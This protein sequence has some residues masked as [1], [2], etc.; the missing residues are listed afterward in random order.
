MIMKPGRRSVD[1]DAWLVLVDVMQRLGEKNT[2]GWIVVAAR[3]DYMNRLV[4]IERRLDQIARAANGG[5]HHFW[6]A[7]ISVEQEA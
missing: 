4:V 1:G 3:N 6:V 2:A 5:P 7:S